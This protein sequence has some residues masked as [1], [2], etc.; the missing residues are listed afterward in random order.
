MIDQL[1]GAVKHPDCISAESQYL[2]FNECPVM[3]LNKVQ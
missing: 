3:T 1:S 2:P